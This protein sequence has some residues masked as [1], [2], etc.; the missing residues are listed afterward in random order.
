MTGMTSPRRSSGY[1]MVFVSSNEGWGGS[2]ELW[3]RA[4]MLLARSGDGILAAKANFA[5]LS[6]AVKQL[7]AAGCRVIDLKGATWWTAPMRRLIGVVGPVARLVRGRW[8][9]HA[10]RAW[11]PDLVVIS[12]GL[13]YDGWDLGQLCRK[14]ALPYVLISQKASD[15]YWPSDTQ[16][17][18]LIDAYLGSRAALFVSERNLRLTEEQLGVRLSKGQVVRNPYNA[19]WHRAPA[20]PSLDDGVRLACVARLDA[21]EK[22]QD[23]LLRV[24][25]MPKWR[26]R[27][28]TVRFHGAGHNAQGLEAMARLLDLE[29]VD[30]AGFTTEP[31]ALW[32]DVHGLVLPSR[33]E[34]LPLSLIEASLSERIA[35]ITDIGGNGEAVI[36]GVTG[37]I[38]EAATERA[39]DG[40][41]ERAWQQRDQ[42][43]GMGRAAAAF[44]RTLVGP[45][46]VHDLAMLLLSLV[47]DG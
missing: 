4:A 35:I 36:D 15:L 40:A 14:L 44:T 20:W 45:D 39:L 2:E 37:F 21:R 43:A 23:L 31:A 8:L 3:S 10:L 13:N 29:S 5:P 24:L 12:Q 47:D 27:P 38:A 41:L 6:P 17:A 28:L 33:C 30:F 34:G 22:G 32:A 16:R 19:D 46:P 9:R 25:A 11:R 26:T 7:R 1:R 18:G 42:W